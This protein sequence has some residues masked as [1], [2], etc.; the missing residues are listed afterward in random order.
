M[1][2]ITNRAVRKFTKIIE[3]KNGK[4]AFLY[5]KGGGCNGFSYKFDVLEN[6]KKPHKYDEYHAIGEYNLY[7]C[8][9]SLMFILNTQIDYIED[10]MGSRFDFQNSNISSKCGCGTS[11][12][13]QD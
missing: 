13:F 8:H 2:S 12:N 1:I 11:F 10:I 6:D 3:S 5:L 7:L 9:K 4:S